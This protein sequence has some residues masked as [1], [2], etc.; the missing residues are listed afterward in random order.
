MNMLTFLMGDDGIPLDYRHMSGFS[1]NT[2]KFI[3]KNHEE[4]LVKMLWNPK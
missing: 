4:F 2:F 1:V 3:N